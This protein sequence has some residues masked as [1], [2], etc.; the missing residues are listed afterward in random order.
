MKRIHRKLFNRIIGKLCIYFH[1]C[2]RMLRQNM[3]RKN[4]T[5]LQKKYIHAFYSKM[6][7]N[8]DE[9][10][11]SVSRPIP[12]MRLVAVQAAYWIKPY[13]GVSAVVTELLTSFRVNFFCVITLQFLSYMS[14]MTGNL[15]I[16]LKFNT[17][18]MYILLRK[19]M[20]VCLF[21]S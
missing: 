3:I 19:C 14:D 1:S 16:G 2:I 15:S 7:G 17:F 5:E 20:C 10:F 8:A 21:F 9:E 6:M 13:V 11:F 4:L 12:W 18:P